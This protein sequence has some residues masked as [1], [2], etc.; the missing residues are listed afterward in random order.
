MSKR[1]FAFLPDTNR[2]E[3]NIVLLLTFTT[4]RASRGLPVVVTAMRA[5][6]GPVSENGICRNLGCRE[7]P[8]PSP[9]RFVLCSAS[10]YTALVCL[11]RTNSPAT[12]LQQPVA[13]R[14]KSSQQVW[15]YP[16]RRQQDHVVP[17]LRLPSFPRMS[18]L[19]SWRI[20]TWSTF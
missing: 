11:H 5:T 20:L 3:H 14:N 10:V 1:A 15:L 18:L 19:G 16:G 9:V 8:S 2:L 7:T 12:R 4:F 13:T 6:E 17:L